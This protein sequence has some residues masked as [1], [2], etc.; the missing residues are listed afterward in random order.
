MR[1]SVAT[2]VPSICAVVFFA[3]CSSKK[4]HPP[5][6]P[7]PIVDAGAPIEDA[8][9]PEADDAGAPFFTEADDAGLSPTAIGEAAFDSAIDLAIMTAAPKLAP[10][11]EREGQPGRA[12]LT[13]GGHFAMMIT[14]QPNRCYTIIANSPPGSVEQLDM[15]LYAP[16]LFNVQAG[17]SSAGDKNMPVI[18]K[19]ATA[20]CPILPIAVPYKIDVAATK[21]AGRIGVHV[22]G[23]MK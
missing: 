19:G 1:K 18:G 17:S 11:M 20:L 6:T 9:A 12:T 15:K 8:G 23:R 14:L 16:P 21:G 10:K 7:T 2:I 13:E 22:F 4:Q 5:M 3:A